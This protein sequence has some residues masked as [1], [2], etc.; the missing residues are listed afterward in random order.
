LRKSPS[1]RSAPLIAGGSF[2]RLYQTHFD[3][4][5]CFI[6]R[7][8][9]TSQDAEDL[10]QRV[11]MVAL[12]QC[13]KSEPLQQPSAWLRSVALR[14]IHEHFRWW[15]VRHAASW[16]VAQSWAGRAKDDIDPECEALASELLQRVKCV[17]YRMSEKLRDTLVLLDIEGLSARDAAELLGVPFNTMRSRH[18][19]AREE[20]KRLWDRSQTRREIAN[21]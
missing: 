14:I 21:D 10:A 4:V 17:L 15:R 13:A 11:F 12:R 20:F 9:I 18:N 5:M 1:P 16:L 7:F 3:E 19:L 6:L 8:G 2:R